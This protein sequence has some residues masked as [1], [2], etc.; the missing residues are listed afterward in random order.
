[1]SSLQRY[2]SSSFT[3]HEHCG[4]YSREVARCLKRCG[5]T[6]I[7]PVAQHDEGWKT[8]KACQTPW[9]EYRKCGRELMKSIDWSVA[10]CKKQGDAYRKCTERAS[11]QSECEDLELEALKCNT[12]K[13]RWR[14]SGGVKPGDPVTP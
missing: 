5:I 13:I 8:A 2:D 9:E 11:S 4:R 7:D 3:L 12:N 14:M 1:M 10:K 6:D